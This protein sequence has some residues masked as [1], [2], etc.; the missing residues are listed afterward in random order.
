VGLIACTGG[1]NSSPGDDT[2]RETVYTPTL[3]NER[4]NEGALYISVLEEFSIVNSVGN[5]IYGMIRRPDPALYPKLRFAAVI[6]VPG[7]INP[8]RS[9]VLTVEAIALAEAGMVVVGFN[10]EGRLDSRNPDDIRSEGEEDYNGFRNQDTLAEIFEYVMELPYVMP[11]NIGIRTQSYGITM[12]AGCAARHPEIPIKYIVDGEGPSS[13][14]VT[15][16]EPWALYSPVGHSNHGKY[17]TVYDILG[18]YSAYRD[19]SEENL[20]FWE[21]REAVAFIGAFDGMY[22]R[23][24]AEWDHSQPPSQPSEIGMFHD[25]PTWWQCKHTC[26]MVNAAVQGGV[27]WVRVNLPEQGN[28]VNDIFDSEY[29]PTF[30]PDQLNSEPMIPVRAVLEMA[31]T[32]S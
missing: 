12:G 14:F 2:G 30:L 18:H 6:K 7:G 1:G 22:L 16:Q 24:Q 4:A 10:A 13:S 23:L 31:R 25:P 11:Y 27:P 32:E 26:D 3:P 29:P 28:L 21:E 8:G 15:V 19:P 5:T 9:E 17:E 20:A